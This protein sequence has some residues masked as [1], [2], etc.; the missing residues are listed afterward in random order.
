MSI[1]TFT[2]NYH[3]PFADLATVI[4]IIFWV[5]FSICV[6]EA[7][8]WIADKI[9]LWE[10]QPPHSKKAQ[11][12]AE[13]SVTPHYEA[14]SSEKLIAIANNKNL[15]STRSLTQTQLAISSP[16]AQYNQLLLA[17]SRGIE[18]SKSTESL[19]KTESKN[20]DKTSSENIHTPE[21]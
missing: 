16:R 19:A 15:G 2:A 12:K 7:C 5:L 20:G 6:K 4:I 21:H 17:S 9:H 3:N 18:G 1:T 11:H 8:L 10:V 13:G 14:A